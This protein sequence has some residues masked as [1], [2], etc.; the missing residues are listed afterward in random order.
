[1][2]HRPLEPPV[3][4]EG[5]LVFEHPP[6]RP[7]R[8]RGVHRVGSGQNPACTPCSIQTHHSPIGASWDYKE[9]TYITHSLPSRA[10]KWPLMTRYTQSDIP[11]RARAP[12]HEDD[13]IRAGTGL[14]VA[15]CGWSTEGKQ[16]QPGSP[17]L[18]L[19]LEKLLAAKLPPGSHAWLQA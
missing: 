6:L 8:V 11:L 2:G 12:F 9:G 1:M 15:A 18:A 19:S 17:P 16:G 10:R 5:A 3:P 13:G 7:S 4:W 14:H